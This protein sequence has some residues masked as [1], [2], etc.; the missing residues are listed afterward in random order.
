MS[1]TLAGRFFTTKPPRKPKSIHVRVCVFVCSHL[2]IKVLSYRRKLG[3]L[4][5]VTTEFKI[6][7]PENGYMRM[8]G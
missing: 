2:Y 3:K 1:P 5:L 8:Y 4:N 6:R 7:S